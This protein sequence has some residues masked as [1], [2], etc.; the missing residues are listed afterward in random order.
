MFS[1]KRVYRHSFWT[2][3]L[4]FATLSFAADARNVPA[5]KDYAYVA[6]ILQ[7]LIQHELAD[8]QLPAISIA[9]VD[10]DQIVYAHGFGFADPAR[11]IP[12]SAETIYRVGSVSKLFTDI[13]IMQ[14]VEQ[15][16]LNLDA[17]LSTY[18]PDFKPAN[19]FSKPITL[20]QL[21]SHRAGI[22][23]EPLAG[24]YFDS[25][26]MSLGET[27]RSLNGRELIYEP[28]TR[29]KYSN[30]GV[31]VVGYTLETVT[32]QPFT[33]QVKRSVLLPF[34][35]RS[36]SF[37]L[38]PSFRNRLA[39]SFIW[40]YDGR[41]FPAPIFAPGMSPAGNLYST[42]TD[43]GRFLIAL[44]KDDQGPS[45]PVLKS[46]TLAQMWQPQFG[47]H[48]P[49]NFGIGFMLGALDGHRVVGHGGAVY[50]FAT[51]IEFLPDDELGAVAVT[52]MDSA[53]GVTKHIVQEALRLMLARKSGKSLDKI[54]TSEPIPEDIAR[55]VVGRYGS[56]DKAVDLFQQRGELYFRR[57]IGGTQVRVRKLGDALVTDDRLQ[58]GLKISPLDNAIKV[59]EDV[60]P[61]TTLPKLGTLPTDFTGL[62][63]QYG[64]DFNILYILEREGRLVSLIEWYEFEPLEQ[65]SPDVFLYP[66]RGLYDNE[67]C[68]FTRDAKG[69]ATQVEV[70]GV[71]FKK[72]SSQHVRWDP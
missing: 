57:T 6:A 66:R 21:M 4:L 35:M 10:G 71:V 29:T 31:S 3:L 60:L 47:D 5:R 40:T 58:W 64:W 55:Q 69:E 17:P 52:T 22:L 56:G 24:H 54:S 14:L 34:G 62:I 19:Q 50:G 38:E 41:V 39:K 37:E 46:S 49:A 9:L 23:R 28:E 61:R 12:A 30:A 51:E 13:G 70:G 7:E 32:K 36:S 44:G 25:R 1:R 43:L 63:G 16:K 11:R 42:V 20:R 59:G 33:A 8:K 27:V 2:W 15:G 67:K 45:S 18:L 48:P 68:T 26:Q 53:N 72:L 65:L